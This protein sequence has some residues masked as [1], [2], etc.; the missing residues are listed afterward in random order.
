MKKGFLLSKAERASMAQRS[1]AENGAAQG[2]G[3]S[4]TAPDAAEGISLRPQ[5]FTFVAPPEVSVASPV[6]DPPAH[7]DDTY[8]RH[9]ASPNMSMS[10][11]MNIP[12]TP[13]IAPARKPQVPHEEPSPNASEP[14]SGP[15]TP[16]RPA[17]TITI[18]RFYNSGATQGGLPSPPLIFHNSLAQ[19][20]V[21]LP[22]PFTPSVRIPSHT[23]FRDDSQPATPL[24]A[25]AR[26]PKTPGVAD[27][28]EIVVPPVIADAPTTSQITQHT[29]T[30]SWDVAQGSTPATS[31]VLAMTTDKPAGGAG[32][33]TVIYEGPAK[34]YTV[35]GLPAGFYHT[36]RVKGLVGKDAGQFSP[37]ARCRTEPSLPDTPGQLEFTGK[38][39]NSHS[40]KW[41]APAV[42]G[43][44]PILGYDLEWDG[45][46]AKL[47][48]D[49]FVNLYS[50]AERRFKTATT[51]SPGQ[52]YRY[53]VR[54]RNDLGPSDF[55]KAIAG[56]T[57]ATL[58]SRPA[59]P[60]AT[61]VGISR[62]ALAWTEPSECGGAEITSY[63]LEM[64]DTASGYGYR[65]VYN[66]ADL[67]HTCTGLRP[68][69]VYRFR[70]TAT[71]SQGNSPVSS[72]LEVKT[73]PALPSAPGAPFP[74]GKP[75]VD[76]LDLE[77]T[78]NPAGELVE[79]YTIESGVI[80]GK[81]DPE[82]AAVYTGPDTKLHVGALQPGTPYSFRLRATNKGGHGPWCKPVLLSTAAVP[83]S[84]PGLQGVKT[85]ARNAK[86]TIIAPASTG[87]AA[88]I[89]YRIYYALDGSDAWACGYEGLA[90]DAT[91]VGLVPDHTYKMKATVLNHAGE[92]A[93]SGIV[94]VTTAIAPPDAPVNVRVTATTSAS[95]SLAWTAPAS[96]GSPIFEYK[97]ELSDNMVGDESFR[98]VSSD[99]AAAAD[100]KGL[101]PAFAYRLRV[102][103][104]NSVGAGAYSAVV[105]DT[106]APGAPTAPSGVT[107]SA[108]TQRSATVSWKAASPRGAPVQQY[109]IDV[110]GTIHTVADDVT[111][112]PLTDLTPD[113]TYRI[114]VQAL[115]RAGEGAFSSTVSFKTQHTAPPAPRVEA[116][117]GQGFVKLTW[118]SAKGT[119]VEFS[120]VEQLTGE[121]YEPVFSGPAKTFKV[122]KLSPCT[123][124]HF[125]VR[126]VNGAGPGEYRS[127]SCTTPAAP[128]P[129]PTLECRLSADKR[130]VALEWH[131]RG[132]DAYELQMDCDEEAHV[133][134]EDRAFMVSTDFVRIWTGADRHVRVDVSAVALGRRLRFRVRTRGTN[135]L[136]SPFSPIQVVELPRP[137]PVVSGPASSTP[138]SPK[139]VGPSTPAAAAQTAIPEKPVLKRPFRINIDQHLIVFAVVMAFSIFLVVVS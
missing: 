43:G 37:P 102:Q 80:K 113:T 85:A 24:S 40:L 89:S 118:T 33:E 28:E 78:A 67:S 59:A 26:G 116:V 17:P 30:V 27:W 112:L 11:A 119:V 92:S 2:S 114:R 58:P 108:V 132:G 103:A 136:V 8:L 54:A 9:V 29:V 75:T 65:S 104:I 57:A 123:E 48:E 63:G 86:A 97:V 127:V 124:Y 79:T 25:A 109:K 130:E 69:A 93:P 46:D 134:C 55:T 70:V 35:D 4:A 105:A 45:G 72:V 19:A 98:V 139:A 10:D 66:G 138:A 84:A 52:V 137:T 47:P 60:T 64:E 135:D 128:L 5:V 82:Y 133:V 15:T 96:N 87:G 90:T 83:P 20:S 12:P 18:R 38:T 73:L 23:V 34:E 74:V 3:A 51:L 88:I 61:E 121:E 81:G 122:S 100:V 95:I 36:F 39:R 101:Q 7:P 91:V 44:L 77:W 50:G 13:Y 106:T 1:A 129:T 110:S 14:P 68:L 120:E 62:V 42:T 126:D 99:A 56:G 53:R 32:P 49:K 117:P 125:R 107:V 76:A 22:E 131:G 111:S 115:S 71:N 94:K 21:P 6:F 31:F 41:A 16:Q